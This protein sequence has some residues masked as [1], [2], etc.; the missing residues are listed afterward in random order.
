VPAQD[1]VSVVRAM[2]EHPLGLHAAIIGDVLA[3]PESTVILQTAFGGQRM[4]DMLI[5]DQL[6]RIC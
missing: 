3:A 1:A 4:L 2:K 6:P 5:G